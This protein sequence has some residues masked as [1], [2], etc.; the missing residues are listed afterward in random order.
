MIAVNT[1][2]DKI[3]R[4]LGVIL[5]LIVMLGITGLATAA[6]IRE[7]GVPE[8]AVAKGPTKIPTQVPIEAGVPEAG[9]LQTSTRFLTETGGVTSAQIIPP[10]QWTKVPTF[11]QINW[12]KVAKGTTLQLDGKDTGVVTAKKLMQGTGRMKAA[13]NTKETG[14]VDAKIYKFEIKVAEDKIYKFY[15]HQYYGADGKALLAETRVKPSGQSFAIREIA[16]A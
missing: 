9:K 5:S 4:L 16:L 13:T 10:M 1:Y 7:V 8:S 6:V 11:Q 15:I 14:A 12:D 3:K 2:I